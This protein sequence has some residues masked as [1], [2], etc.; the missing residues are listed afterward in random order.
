MLTVFTDKSENCRKDSINK[1]T[2]DSK[3][4]LHHLMVEGFK[5]YFVKN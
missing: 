5:Y 2:N 1:K 3:K 4:S